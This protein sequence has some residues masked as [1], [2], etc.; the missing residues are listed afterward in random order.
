MVVGEE[1][2]VFDI[3]VRNVQVSNF[4]A[5]PFYKKRLANFDN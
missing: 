4:R 3:F 2:E 1:I 5:K